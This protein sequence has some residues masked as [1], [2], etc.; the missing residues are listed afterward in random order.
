VFGPFACDD[1]FGSRA[2]NPLEL[3]HN[4]ITRAQGPFSLRMHHRSWGLMLIQANIAAPSTLLDFPTRER[5]IDELRSRHYDVVGISGIVMNIGKVR[6][7]CRLVRR[8][9]PRSTIVVGGHVTA[10][11][12]VERIIDA[13]HV[14]KGEGVRWMREF[15]GEPVDTAV[16]HPLIR[17]SFGFRLMGIAAPRGGGDPAA[18]I[19][20]SVGCPMGCNFC[21]TSAF[22]GGKGRFVNFYETGAALFEVMSEV[23]ARLRVRTFFMMDENFLL[24]KKRALELLELMKAHGKSWSLSVFSSA[25]ALRKY[26]M[27]QLV[28]LGISWV[29]MGLESAQAT[30]AKLRDSDTLALTRDLQSHGIHVQGSTIIGLE[31]HTAANLP[32][33]IEHA[34]AHDADCHQFMLYTPVPG[35]PL[36]AE[37]VRSGHLL[38]DVDLADIHGQ[39]KFNFRHPH[40]G[41][42][43]SSGWLERAFQRDYEANGPSLYR[44]MRTTYRGWARYR[45]DADARVRARFARE[46]SKLRNGYGAALWAMEMFLRRSQAEVS[47]RIRA[48]RRQIEDEFAGLTPLIDRVAGRV[49]LHAARREFSRY[50]LGRPLEPMTFV[51]RRN[52]LP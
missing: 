11:P 25:N 43:E 31:H 3:Y 15:L 9:S 20:P 44:I 29:W 2:I 7:M 36:Y 5:F 37:T 10:L 40:I 32:S 39:Y 6:E 23:E 8:H 16:V 38:S 41:R 49:L 13:D 50:P 18:T 27:R 24:Y 30:Y 46:G 4:Q 52:W 17:S 26:T 22:F 33:E 47:L 28:E 51:D 14:V 1:E 45:H 42:D 12:G 19:I 34:V 21:S 35:T 48:L